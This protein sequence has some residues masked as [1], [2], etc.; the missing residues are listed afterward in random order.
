MSKFKVNK[1][2]VF[3]KAK[4]KEKPTRYDNVSLL[5]TQIGTGT[6]KYEITIKNNE[7]EVVRDLP[8]NLKLVAFVDDGRMIY[9]P[10]V[11]LEEDKFICHNAMVS[12]DKQKVETPLVIRHHFDFLK[13][14][15]IEMCQ[16]D[17]EAEWP[18]NKDFEKSAHFCD[19]R[20]VADA[21]AEKELLHI[22][23]MELSPMHKAVWLSEVLTNFFMKGYK[24]AK[25]IDSYDF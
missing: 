3:D 22:A 4:E 18:T 9:I 21:C 1:L 25:E 17:L 16:N 23:E 14:N 12:I 10:N 11:V 19:V 6:V 24:Y 5:Y 15:G 13:N 2:F 8:N 20:R 7:N